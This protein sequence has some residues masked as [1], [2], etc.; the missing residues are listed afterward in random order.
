LWTSSFVLFTGGIS[1]VLLASLF[2]LIDGPPG[3]KRGLRPWIALGT[4]ALAAYILSELL[5]I[6]LAAIPVTQGRN[7]QQFLFDLLPHWLGPPALVSMWYSILFV[8][9]CTLP[10]LELYRRRIFVKV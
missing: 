3:V 7:L 1:M 9:V 6:V 10:V 8:V 2:W 4:N 5:A